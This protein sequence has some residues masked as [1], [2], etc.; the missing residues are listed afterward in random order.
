MEGDISIK[1][2]AFAT[3][4]SNSCSLFD[5]LILG[6]TSKSMVNHGF[7]YLSQS[8]GKKFTRTVLLLAS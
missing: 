5:L 8:H 3:F 1:E 6:L 7:C 2:K 4:F